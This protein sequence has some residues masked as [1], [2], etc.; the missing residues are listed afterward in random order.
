[1]L[2]AQLANEARLNGATWEEIADALEITKQ[3]AYQ[4]FHGD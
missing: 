1:V 3:A 4:R 2:E